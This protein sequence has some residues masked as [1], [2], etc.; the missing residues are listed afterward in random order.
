[1]SVLLALTEILVIGFICIGLISYQPYILAL[2]LIIVL[3]LFYGIYKFIE[4]K[5]EEKG[6]KINETAI[7]SYSIVLEVVNAF[8]DVVLTNKEKKIAEE[9][10]TTQ[11]ELFDAKV[12]LKIFSSVPRKMFDISLIIGIIIILTL[13]VNLKNLNPTIQPILKL[14]KFPSHPFEEVQA[15]PINQSITFKQVSFTFPDAKETT[16]LRDITFSVKKGEKIGIIGVSGSGKTTLL[17]IL[18]RLLKEDTGCIEIDGRLLDSSMDACF[19]KNIGFVQQKI[20]IKNGS[21][22]S[23][24]AFG[25]EE[26][27]IRLAHLNQAIEQAMLSDFVQSHP[28]GLE[29]ELGEKGVKLSGGQQQRV[30][31][32]RALYKRAQILVFDEPTSALDMETESVIVDTIKHLAETDKTI[33][34]VAHR[35]TTLSSCDRIYELENGEIRSCL[36]YQEL[37]KEKLLL[38]S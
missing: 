30:G 19:Q 35:I 15:L 31:I 34:I 12:S 22:K 7:K 8:I 5:I 21:L 14:G 17:K 1:M 32:A 28:Q 10:L 37:C 2:L 26:E 33:F 3:P 9:F 18:L 25:E 16:I 20:F 6:R 11:S 23:N 4:N 38:A 27:E 36:S 24:I 29:M 13:F